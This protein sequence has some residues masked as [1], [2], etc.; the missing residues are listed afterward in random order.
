[1][2]ELD[3]R[4]ILGATGALILGSTASAAQAAMPT[5]EAYWAKIASQY[6]VTHDVIQLE[7]GMW[8]MMPKPVQEAY[9]RH[10]E[11]INR[12]NS[13]YARR[14]Y[15]D[16]IEKVR[17]HAA[18]DLGVH[19]DEIAFARGATEA[20][21]TLI[22]GYNRLK[23]G[24]A[25]LYADLDYE[26]T[27]AAFRQLQARRG[28][29][30]V[31]IDLPEPATHQNLIDAYD[32]ALKANP[33]VRLMLLTHVSHRTGLVLPVAEITALAKSRGVDVI[34]D[35]AHAWGQLDFKLPDTG[36][37][38]IGLTCQKWIG[39]PMGVGIF[40]VK[41]ARQDALDDGWGIASLEPGD[42]RRK[43][44]TGTTNMA[45]FLALDD[46]LT[47]HEQIGAAAKEARLRHLR[48]RWAEPLRGRI[49]ILTPTDPRLTGAITSFRLKGKTSVEDNR[50]LA[51][52]LLRRFNIFTVERTGVAKG[53]CIRVSCA[54]FTSPEQT[55]RLVA[56]LASLA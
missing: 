10:S 33:R 44:Q 5:D 31:A 37:D 36:A 34:L 38:F 29:D 26:S 2:S 9:R 7:N 35:S 6:D 17:A 12:N 40:Y 43:I 11:R 41:K 51:E 13:Y 16:D 30:V 1:M 47:F 4:D 48:D 55:D 56:A 45:A 3:R 24:D 8:G 15:E 21:M 14:L 27:Q 19:V 28:V 32:A 52:T 20:L 18:R 54:L 42:I 50:Q 53:A 49:E 22:V 25:V 23:P 46:A 39:S